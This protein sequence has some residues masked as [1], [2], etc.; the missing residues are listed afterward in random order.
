LAL[1]VLPV[2]AVEEPGGLQARPVD[3]V[4]AAGIDADTMRV[5]A[6]DVEGMHAAM[7]AEGVL[8]DAGAEGVGLE[9]GLAAQQ[10]EGR[11]VAAEVQD[12]L[13]GADRAAAVGQELEIDLGAKPHPAAMASA[14]PHFQHVRLL[15]LTVA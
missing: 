12:A 11:G 4:Q 14:F 1:R 10:L 8:R 2:A 3:I 5:G 9:R 6:R 7:R 13:L 15:V